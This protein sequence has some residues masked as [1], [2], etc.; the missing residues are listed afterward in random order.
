MSATEP[1]SLHLWELHE[2]QARVLAEAKR[3]NVVACGRRW[4]KTTL[5]M[6]RLIEP[7]LEGLPVA[8]FAPTNP[9]LTEVWR[10][11]C[12][13]VAPITTRR[14]ERDHRLELLGRGVIEMWSL[15]A[16]DAPRGR[17]YARAVIDEASMVRNL[18][19][20]WQRVIRPTLTDFRGDAWFPSTPRGLNGF[21]TLFQLGQDPDE[22]EWASWRFPTLSNPHIDGAEVEQA[23]RDLS[24]SAFAQEYLAEF[25]ADGTTVFRR[26]LEACC[27]KPTPPQQGHNYVMGVDW[28]RHKDFTVASVIDTSVRPLRQVAIERTNRIEFAFQAARIKEL[29]G[30]YKCVGAVVEKNSIGEAPTE[31]L[32]RMGLRVVPWTST[33]LAKAAVIEALVLAL[34]RGELELLDDPVQRGE[35]LAYGAERMA[36]GLLR[37]G[38]PEGGHDD[39]VIALALAHAGART[40]PRSGR[41]IDFEVTV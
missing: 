36:S 21:H 15:E 41:L 10:T 38:A 13:V 6:D 19:E 34:E 32:A 31:S 35:L 2:A 20:Q 4:G 26:V 27:H 39:T 25:L 3:F 12:D 17:A 24:E 7:S 33:N 14:S 29:Y 5:C 11:V 8:W 28:G 16:G 1:V 23:R 30:R 18:V 22:G 40:P 9:M 37:Y